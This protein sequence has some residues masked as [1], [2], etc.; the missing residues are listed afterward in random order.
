MRF[1][2]L[3]EN[4]N[5]GLL[6]V[7]RVASGHTSLPILNNVL[8]E[9]KNETIGLTT[10]DLEVGAQTFIRGK[11]EEEGRITVPAGL[12]ASYVN[13]LPNKQVLVVLEGNDVLISC[14]K[15]KTR[16]KGIE[17]TDFPIIPKIEKEG[18]Y[19]VKKG[20][21]KKGIQQ[22]LFT[23][24]PNE[25][26]P[27][28]SGALLMFGSVSSQD[29]EVMADKE[30]FCLVGTDSYRLAEKMIN[31]KVLGGKDKKSEV[32]NK[33]IVPHNSLQE[34][35]RILEHE[36]DE[37]VRIYVSENQIM[38]CVGDSELVSRVVSGQ[39]PDYK[40]IIP[41]DFKT[42]V[43]FKVS[44]VLTAVKTSSLFSQIGI[45]DVSLSFKTGEG[46]TVSSVN[47]QIGESTSDI[48]CEV[49]GEEN[50]IVFNYRYILDGLNAL[51]G[52]EG[53]LEMMDNASPAVLRLA[54]GDDYLYIIMPIKQ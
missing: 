54:D 47:T 52:E 22:V 5:K 38:F 1:S 24:V 37:E 30:R 7:S 13:L 21:F 8:L 6:V 25:T 50:G 48:K 15:Q 12:L 40:E 32:G 35:L 23:I 26:R 28:I 9:A 17:A 3:K 51:G 36:E 4:L 18:G 39:Y 10:T 16:I 20:D 43:R 19:V 49:E 34:V 2:C 31:F 42:R 27:E 53:V 44:E 41:R 33:V 46:L 29:N 14:E 11:I 45:N